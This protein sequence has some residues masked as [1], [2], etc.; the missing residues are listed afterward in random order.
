MAEESILFQPTG[1]FCQRQV[2]TCGPDEPL[3]AASATMREK[4][5]SSIVVCEGRMPTGI[6]TDRDLRNK[7]VS[8]G[9]DP[10]K[11]AVRAVMNAP[12]ITVGEDDFL[13]EALHRMTRHGIHRVCVVDNAGKLTGI[14]TDSDI[15]R[16]QTRSPQ[17]M[18]REIEE[19]RSVADLGK[20]HDRVQDLVLHLTGSGVQTHDLIRMIAHLND[21]ILVRL[22]TLLRTERYRGLTERFAF[23]VLGSEGR[24]EQT[25]TTDQDNA[26]VYADDLAPDEIEQLEAFS[27]ELIDSLIAIGVPSCPGGIMAKNEAWRRS[28]TDWNTVLDQ[29]LSTPSPENILNCSM[30]CD[31]RIISGDSSLERELKTLVTGRLRGDTRYLAHMGAN[32]LRFAPP[33]SFFGKIKVERSG[34][35]RGKLDLKKG[36]IFA[37]TEGIKILA[38]EAGC[39]H[40]GTLQRLHALVDAQVFTSQEAQNLQASF[41]FLVL[42]RLRGQVEAIRQGLAPTNHLALDQLNRMEQGRLKLAL[43]EVISLQGL[44]KRRFRLDLYG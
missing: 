43:E 5:I 4:N 35:Q 8:R 44:L 7:V 1:T 40:G 13:F 33:L 16:L 36:G 30:F 20:L 21:Q 37:I 6:M 19:A 3:V 25:L 28:F 38:L 27:R 26:I 12:L 18:I 22:I 41:T 14:I 23:I 34:D 11:L 32:V 31:L 42:L 29:W 39:L 24:Q 2:I 15:L 9:E 17:Q 10:R